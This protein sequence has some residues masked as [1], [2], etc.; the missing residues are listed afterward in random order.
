M[1]KQ[2]PYLNFFLS[3]WKRTGVFNME[4]LVT[5]QRVEKLDIILEESSKSNYM[6][7]KKLKWDELIYSE[8][9]VN[10]L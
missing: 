3:A 6:P 7:M 5:S 4:W 2:A 10:W 8:L 1:P 9:M